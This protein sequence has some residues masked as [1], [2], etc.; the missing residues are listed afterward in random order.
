MKDQYLPNISNHDVLVAISQCHKITRTSGILTRYRP[1]VK[2]KKRE[3]ER[4]K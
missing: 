4:M 2:M 3:L 1:A